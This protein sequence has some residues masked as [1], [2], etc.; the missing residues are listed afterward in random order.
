[1]RGG[2]PTPRPVSTRPVAWAEF[3][4]GSHV[5]VAVLD[6]HRNDSPTRNILEAVMGIEPQLSRFVVES[7]D[8]AI[9][10]VRRTANSPPRAVTMSARAVQP[11]N[12]RCCWPEF[13][14]SERLRPYS[15]PPENPLFR[16]SLRET[17][18]SDQRSVRSWYDVI[19]PFHT[20]RHVSTYQP[21]SPYVGTNTPSLV[22]SVRTRQ[23]S[24]GTRG[25]RRSHVPCATASRSR[26]RRS[27]SRFKGPSIAQR[28]TMMPGERN[29]Q[30]RRNGRYEEIGQS[31]E[32]AEA[33]LRA[34]ELFQQRSQWWLPAAAKL[35]G[36]EEHDSPVIYRIHVNRVTGR[37][38]AREGGAQ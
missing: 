1:M 15:P 33:R 8:S 4:V 24:R 13:T 2:V 26:V 7:S 11:A 10:R 19:V 29:D 36:G 18:S 37:R 12:A 32:H 5:G 31:S 27:A 16:R 3:H 25:V 14:R 17:A 6:R 28:I 35:R 9:Q 34:H 20:A 23:P 30:Y 22:A 38:A 21:T